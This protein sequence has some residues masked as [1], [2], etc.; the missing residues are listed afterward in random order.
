MDSRRI[1]A[2]GILATMLMLAEFRLVCGWFAVP[3]GSR[4][5]RRNGVDVVSS[6]SGSRR[7]G[8]DVGIQSSGWGGC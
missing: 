5:R 4:T 6:G 3:K 7:A 8:V 1:A 2:W